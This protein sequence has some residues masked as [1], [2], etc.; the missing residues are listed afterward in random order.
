MCTTKYGQTLCLKAPV[1]V[2][3]VGQGWICKLGCP[4]F[5]PRHRSSSQGVQ[6]KDECRQGLMAGEEQGGGLAGLLVTEKDALQR[7]SILSRPL[8]LAF[9]I[10][11]PRGLV[12]TVGLIGK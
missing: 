1:R 3:G 7:A 12:A 4:L 9:C 6:T 10:G 8:A 11:W 2:E 5:L